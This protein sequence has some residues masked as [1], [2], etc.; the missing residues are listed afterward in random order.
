MGVSIRLNV[1][2]LQILSSGEG[3]EAVKV[4]NAALEKH[5]V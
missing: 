4:G 3:E 1:G 5:V 2:S